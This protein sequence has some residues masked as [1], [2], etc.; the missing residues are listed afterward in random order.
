MSRRRCQTYWRAGALDQQELAS[1]GHENAYA[2]VIA[3]PHELP[4]ATVE[5]LLSPPTKYVKQLA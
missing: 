3:R 2:R 5:R 4:S 1:M